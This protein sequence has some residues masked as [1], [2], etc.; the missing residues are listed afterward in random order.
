MATLYTPGL[1]EMN[2]LF[3]PLVRKA[4]H[5]SIPPYGLGKAG[6]FVAATG[7]CET[8]RSRISAAHREEADF[9]LDNTFLL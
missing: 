2:Q 4:I 1:L 6:K 5:S 7:K 8:V 9:I 3:S